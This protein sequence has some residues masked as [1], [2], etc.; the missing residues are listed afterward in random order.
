MIDKDHGQPDINPGIRE[1]T[2]V[3]VLPEPQIG[4]DGIARDVLLSGK[5]GRI[6]LLSTDENVPMKN[7]FYKPPNGQR[8]PNGCFWDPTGSSDQSTAVHLNTRGGE[9]FIMG[10][11]TSNR[12]TLQE[13]DIYNV[14]TDSWKKI[15]TGIRRGVPASILL[16]TGK[17][18]NS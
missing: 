2:R 3:F 8:D 13:I 6:W 15:D 16:P 10:G 4:P 17:S 11:C 7:R 5:A 1:Y 14:K 12:T 9:L 18:F